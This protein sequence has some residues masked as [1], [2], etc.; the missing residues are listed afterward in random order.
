MLYSCAFQKPL[1]QKIK[2]QNIHTL[3]YNLHLEWYILELNTMATV[4][5]AYSYKT[6]LVG[7]VK[8]QR[9]EDTINHRHYVV[10]VEL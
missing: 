4:S 2:G 9:R 5:T 6:L 8:N 3:A 10:G 1:A 7:T